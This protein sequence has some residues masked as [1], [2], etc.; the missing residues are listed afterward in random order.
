MLTLA[1]D[2]SSEFFSVALAYSQDGATPEILSEA[3]H[4]Q[5]KRHLVDIFASID[6]A[7]KSQNFKP[8][9][10]DHIA[11]TTGPGSFTGVRLGV[12]VARTLAQVH[13]CKIS[14]VQAHDALALAVARAN[15]LKLSDTPLILALD[16]R[17]GQVLSG[18]VELRPLKQGLISDP[19]DLPKWPQGLE[20][21]QG[22]IWIDQLPQNALLFG[23]ASTR[24]RERVSHPWLDDGYAVVKASN[25]ALLGLEAVK[26]GTAVKW[27]DLLPSYVRPP[28]AV[29]L[30]QQ[31]SSKS[32]GSL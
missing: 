14:E 15:M 23:N 31:I 2:T 13:G 8:R 24:Y 18:P 27:C 10:I 12:L 3:T 7:L 28:D 22:Q 32:R 5:A 6:V 11:V 4:G 25:V 1:L 21:L 16:V 17:K 29:P 26:K 20:L 30:E 19:D 9:Q